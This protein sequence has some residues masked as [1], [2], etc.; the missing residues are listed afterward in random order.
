MSNFIKANCI[1]GRRDIFNVVWNKLYKRQF[2]L[3][4]DIRF[5]KEISFG[6]DFL[7]NCLCMKK[8]NSIY[9]IDKAYYNYMRRTNEQTLKMKFLKNKIE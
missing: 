8:T 9:V 1:S 6:E 4:N 3:E 2:I 5:D 7:F